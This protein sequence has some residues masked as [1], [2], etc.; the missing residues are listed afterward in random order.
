MFSFVSSSFVEHSSWCLF[1]PVFL[2]KQQRSFVSDVSDVLS[3]G[4][5]FCLVSAVVWIKYNV[6]ILYTVCLQD[7][8][9]S[10]IIGIEAG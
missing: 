4:P 6:V 5:S 9:F 8:E 1:S 3:G 10:I 2:L 7:T